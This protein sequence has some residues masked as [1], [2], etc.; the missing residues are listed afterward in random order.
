MPA[1]GETRPP[2]LPP[3]P[4]GSPRPGAHATGRARACTQPDSRDQCSSSPESKICLPST[5]H[6]GVLWVL[7]KTKF[8]STCTSDPHATGPPACS[9]PLSSQLPLLCHFL[10]SGRAATT[11]STRATPARAGVLPSQAAQNQ[12]AR[13]RGVQARG[14]ACCWGRANGPGAGC[15]AGGRGVRPGRGTRLRSSPGPHNRTTLANP[16]RAQ[17]HL[18]SYKVG[19]R[20]RPHGPLEALSEM[21]RASVPSAVPPPPQP[22]VWT[23][24]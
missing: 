19:T 10:C 4:P 24:D 17:P 23:G 18:L 15:V 14:G 11:R 3:V 9:G 2:G 7:G 12:R 21:L 13:G 16:V 20:S 6:V 5:L 1:H 8:T 22:P